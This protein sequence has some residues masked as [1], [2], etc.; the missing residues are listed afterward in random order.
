MVPQCHPITALE[1]SYRRV[2]TPQGHVINLVIVVVCFLDTAI[3][4][5]H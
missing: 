2:D 3:T 4:I 1:P 5:L